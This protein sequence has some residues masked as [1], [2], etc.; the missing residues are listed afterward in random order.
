M[1]PHDL[2]EPLDTTRYKVAKPAGV[3]QRRIDEICRR[4]RA[5]TADSALRLGRLFG[6]EAQFDLESID[7]LTRERFEQEAIHYPQAV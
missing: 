2:I 6:T 3:Q 1:P 7:L 5:V 4:T